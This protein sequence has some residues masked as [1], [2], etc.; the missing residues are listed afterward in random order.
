MDA[1]LLDRTLFS[2]YDIS[3]EHPKSWKICFDP[4]RGVNYNSG[5][6]RIE[7][8]VPQKGAQLSLSLNWETIPSSNEEFAE[9]YYEN[10]TKEY[11]RQMK[12]T[13]YEIEIMK[14]IDFHDGKA[15]FI[16]SEYHA[17]LGFVKRKSDAPV[18][19]IQLA[20]YDEDTGRAVVSSLM[21][22]PENVREHEELLRELVC[23]VS[24]RPPAN[25]NAVF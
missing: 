24:C 10:I 7:D 21:G 14:V 4:K 23:S 25:L 6:F 16:V 3:I 11:A 15:A 8:F 1:T 2:I 19:V 5:F 17:T 20:F 9:N 18:R 12:R 22:R 13:P